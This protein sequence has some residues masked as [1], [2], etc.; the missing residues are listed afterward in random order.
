MGVIKWVMV[1]ADTRTGTERKYGV[2]II[3]FECLVCELG[4]SGSDF[5]T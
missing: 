1:S 5:D 4:E 2:G 3:P